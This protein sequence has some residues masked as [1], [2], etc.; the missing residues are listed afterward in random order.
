M[1]T[2]T[3]AIFAASLLAY[4]AWNTRRLITEEITQTVNSETSELSQLYDRRGLHGLALSIQYRALRPGANLYLMTTPSGQAAARS[5]PNRASV[6][7]EGHYGTSARDAGLPHP[8][9][10]SEDEA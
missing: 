5:R 6:D 10:D 3:F 1:P 4:F 9:S 7:V 8:T 2:R